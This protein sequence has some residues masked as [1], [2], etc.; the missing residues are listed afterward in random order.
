V[1]KALVGL[2]VA[3][4]ILVGG[5]L[6]FLRYSEFGKRDACL[7]AGGAWREGRCVGARPGG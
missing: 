5:L 6:L 3:V 7:D 1:K 2:L 4:V